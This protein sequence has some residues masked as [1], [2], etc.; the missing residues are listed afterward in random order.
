M[1]RKEVE[2]ILAVWKKRLGLDCWDIKIRWEIDIEPDTG[3]VAE[4]E[5]RVHPDYE[6][7]SIRVN[8]DKFPTWSDEHANATVVHE[9][10]HVFERGSNL[11]VQSA[12]LLMT[13]A[14]YRLLWDRY[15]HESEGWVDRLAFVLVRL[16]G[17]A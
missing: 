11:A 7:A 17:L 15:E 5:I 12:G 14:A 16:G 4:A 2:R 10:L 1:T 6:Q 3:E 9:L 13:D 8:R